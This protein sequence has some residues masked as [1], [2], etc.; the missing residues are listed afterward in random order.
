MIDNLMFYGL[1]ILFG[2]I[3]SLI[4]WHESKLTILNVSAIFFIP[5][6][7]GVLMYYKL[8]QHTINLEF[9]KSIPSFFDARNF[10]PI[11]WLR[12]YGVIL[13]IFTFYFMSVFRLFWQLKNVV[14]REPRKGQA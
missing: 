10:I 5:I 2:F 12:V 1:S 3:V 7:W 11:D 14:M 4:Y 13:M 9:W 6:I 8:L